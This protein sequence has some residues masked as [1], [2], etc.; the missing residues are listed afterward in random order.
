MAIP[1][2][3][4]HE[5]ISAL[6]RLRDAEAEIERLRAAL[7]EASDLAITLCA[8]CRKNI[9]DKSFNTWAHDKIGVAIINIRNKAIPDEEG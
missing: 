1:V 9:Y 8:E 5:L 7:E 3:P 2:Q 6:T 4:P